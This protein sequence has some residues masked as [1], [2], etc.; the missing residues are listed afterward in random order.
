MK[1]DNMDNQFIIIVVIYKSGK[2]IAILRKDTSYLP[3]VFCCSHCPSHNIFKI[4]S[5]PRRLSYGLWSCFAK[6]GH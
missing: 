4:S 3:Y 2:I 6:C 1:C 5:P